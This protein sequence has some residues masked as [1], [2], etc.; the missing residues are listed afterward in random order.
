M[1]CNHCVMALR[2]ELDA[3]AGVEILE[4]QVGSAV[5][6]FEPAIVPES[7]IIAAVE[8]AGY[9]VVSAEAIAN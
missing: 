5:L 9:S 8:E 2:K 3:V 7:A 6:A 1:S 4:A